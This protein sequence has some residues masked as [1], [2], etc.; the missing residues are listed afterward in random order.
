MNSD[1]PPFTGTRMTR[2][3]PKKFDCDGNRTYISH[4]P[5]GLKSWPSSTRIVPVTRSWADWPSRLCL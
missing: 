5:S 3:G 1:G 2:A 4:F